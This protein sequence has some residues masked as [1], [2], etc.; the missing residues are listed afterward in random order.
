MNQ[1]HDAEA[2]NIVPEQRDVGAIGG[3]PLP[4]PPPVGAPVRQNPA[5][6]NIVNE[7]NSFNLTNM[8]PHIAAKWKTSETLLDDFCKF[9]WSCQRI[10][11]WAGPDG[12]DIYENFNF[13]P[14]QKYDVDYVLRRFEEFC[15][16]ICNFHMAR[17]KLSKVSQHNEESVD[18]LYNR[19]LKIARQCKFPDMDD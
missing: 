19:I 16:P 14:N 1:L 15:K 6:V 17:F 3:D 4:P 7:Y 18:V 12:E 13:L 2:G 5:N 10:L 11:I 9:K 8:T